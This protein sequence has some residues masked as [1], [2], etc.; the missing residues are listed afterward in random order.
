[1]NPFR[2]FNPF[3]VLRLERTLSDLTKRADR[4]NVLVEAE[5]AMRRGHLLTIADA[6]A[7]GRVNDAKVMVDAMVFVLGGK[8]AA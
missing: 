1:M 2:L 4:L 5:L 7:S 6:M 8:D 3:Y